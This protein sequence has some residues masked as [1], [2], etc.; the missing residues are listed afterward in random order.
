MKQ[1][2]RTCFSILAVVCVCWLLTGCNAY[3]LRGKVVHGSYS[4]I[5]VVHESDERL[6]QPGIAG[7]EVLVHRD[8]NKPNRY[9]VGR[10]RTN[11]GGEFTLLLN[12]FGAGWMEEQW[13]VQAIHRGNQNADTLMKLPPNQKKWRLLITLA[14]GTSTPADSEE[15]DWMRDY[16]QFR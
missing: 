11:T 12:E 1:A 2:S 6:Q 8:P 9:L 14:P 15:D 10:T 16:E 4:D 5:E 3:T 13:R 7:A